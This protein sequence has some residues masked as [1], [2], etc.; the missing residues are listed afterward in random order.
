MVLL[1]METKETARIVPF[2]PNERDLDIETALVCEYEKCRE[3]FRGKPGEY[4]YFGRIVCC[5]EHGKKYFSEK[6][7]PGGLYPFCE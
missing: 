2:N 4:N 7:A 6:H 3:K 1:A 5:E